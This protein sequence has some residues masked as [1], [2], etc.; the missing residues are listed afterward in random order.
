M[1]TENSGLSAGIPHISV[2]LPVFNADKY[3]REAILSILAQTYTNFELIVI[4]DGS[5]DGTELI[6]LEMQEIDSR[7]IVISR[8]NRGIV[9]SLNEGINLARG[10]W[11]ARMDADDISLPNR[12]ELQLKRLEQSGAD[13]C[14]TWFEYFGAISGIVIRHPLSDSAIRMSLLFGSP[15]AHPTVMM[16]TDYAKRLLYR[17]EWEKCEDYDLWERAAVEGWVMVNEPSVLLMY[18]QH[19][20][21]ISTLTS[22]NQQNLTKLIRARYWNFICTK[23]DLDISTIDVVHQMR[24]KPPYTM[25]MNVVD[26]AFDKLLSLSVGEARDVLLDHASRLYLR[27]AAYYPD[28]SSRWKRLNSLYGTSPRYDIRV[29][30]FVISKLRIQSDGNLFN[31]MKKLFIRFR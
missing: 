25:D 20:D 6:L 30:L 24:E 27:V 8:E 28:I 15:I 19:A 21:Q 26:K 29:M 10:R 12:F 22:S 1:L 13:V 18:R 2:I 7:I 23:Y 5:R 31:S 9:D 16:K 4:N 17:K 11:I 14:G 3:V